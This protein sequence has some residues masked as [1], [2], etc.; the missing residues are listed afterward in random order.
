MQERSPFR[1]SFP[2]PFPPIFFQSHG[3]HIISIFFFSLF[4]IR[5]GDNGVGKGLS[6]N[7]FYHAL[8][9]HSDRYRLDIRGQLYFPNGQDHVR[10]NDMKEQ[11][12]EMI[13]SHLF[14]CPFGVIIVDELELIHS[15]VLSTIFLF[16]DPS[17]PVIHHPKSGQRIRVHNAFFLFMSDF[18]KLGVSL[19]FNDQQL[20]SHVEA[21]VRL[22]GK[23]RR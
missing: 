18:S 5:A 10:I 13:F 6:A 12:F 4:C 19:Q 2:F 22:E 9:P 8:F 1:F 14:A 21:L 16:L 11:I 23:R 15:D 7:V 20:Q 17:H 3:T